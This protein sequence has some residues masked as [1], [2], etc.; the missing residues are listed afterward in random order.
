MPNIAKVL[1]EEIARIARK[2]VKVAVIKVHK[3]TVRLKKTVAA[4]KRRLASLERGN[5]LLEAGMAKLQTAQPAAVAAEPAP[6][7]RIT[8]K[9]TKSLRRKLR[10]SQAEFARLIGV[11]DQTIYNWESKQGALKVREKTRAALLAVRGLGAREAQTRL[12]AMRAT[13]KAKKV[14]TRRRRQRRR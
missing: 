6:R 13:R 4:L 10:L 1:K 14:A 12:A 11:S 9:G 3:P 7:A 2:E 5:K 8:S